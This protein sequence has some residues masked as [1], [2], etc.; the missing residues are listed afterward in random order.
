MALVVGRGFTVN[1]APFDA[2]AQPSIELVTMQR[3]RLPLMAL[4]TPVIVSKTVLTPEYGATSVR[5]V[6]VGTAMV[7]TCHW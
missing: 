5:S 4:V 7:L 6:Q 1:S 3:Y 2:T